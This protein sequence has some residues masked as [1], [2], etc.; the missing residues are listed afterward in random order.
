MFFFPLN[1]FQLF[2]TSIKYFYLYFWNVNHRFFLE[3]ERE[4][5]YGWFIFFVCIY[6]FWFFQLFIAF[7]K[8][9]S[10]DIYLNDNSYQ[11]PHFRTCL[12]CVSVEWHVITIHTEIWQL[13][14]S[15][16]FTLHLGQLT[17]S[18]AHAISLIA[19][20]IYYILPFCTVQWVGRSWL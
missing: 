4:L 8:V 12:C 18:W 13:L 3:C 14:F 5:N 2:E 16:N 17:L 11:R 1:P 20:I 7:K 15:M 10:G 9:L 19:L 6:I